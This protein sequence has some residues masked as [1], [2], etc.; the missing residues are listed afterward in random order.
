MNGP[1]ANSCFRLSAHLM[2][3]G[4]PLAGHRVYEMIRVV[5]E[6]FLQSRSE[7]LP[8]QIGCMGI[9]GGGLVTAFSAALDERI[10]AAVVS[11]YVNT[12]YGSIL[13]RNH[14]FDNYI[15]R[16]LL[17]SELPDIIGLIAPRPLLIE[18]GD[19]DVVFPIQSAR[20]AYSNI[21]YI[22]EAA[23]AVGR[24]SADFFKGNHEISGL[25]A[26]DWLEKQLKKVDRER[27]SREMYH[28]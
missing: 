12:F 13:D 17:E 28:P 20:E 14:C 26:Y 3:A 10:R 7:V 2:M 19:E 8:D 4:Q 15:P 6:K 23:G 9:S 25:K 27:A 24:L 5:D 16:I 1:T 18:A 22:Y 21:Q 11:G